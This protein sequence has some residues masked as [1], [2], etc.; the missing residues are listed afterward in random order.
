MQQ[1]L[2]THAALRQL[3]A[4]SPARRFVRFIVNAEKVNVVAA[5]L[6]TGQQAAQHRSHCLR[7]PPLPVVEN[8]HAH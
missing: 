2:S 1:K 6:E 7:R 3:R 4:K 8:L 5:I